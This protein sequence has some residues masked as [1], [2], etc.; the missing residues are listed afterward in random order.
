MRDATAPGILRAVAFVAFLDTF[1]MLPVLA[2][3]ARQLGASEA[4]AG[5]IVGVYSLANLLTSAGAGVLLDR[6]GRRLPMAVS[7]MTAGVLVA[8]YG[9][10]RD[11]WLLLMVR[12]LHGASGAVFIPA[13]FALVGEHGQAN[14]V[15]AMGQTGAT[16]GLVALLA[17]PI[18][19]I[20]AERYGEPSLFT[21]IALLMGLTGLSA[22]RWM[23]ER[24]VRPPREARIHPL[25]VL[26]QTALLSVYLLTFG[27]TFAM[28]MLTYR[29]PVMLEAVS[30]G[31]AYRGRLFGLFALLSV[32]VMVAVRRRAALGGAFQRAFTGVA[33]IALGALALETVALPYGAWSAVMLFGAGFGLCFPA[34]HL[35][36]YE[37]VESHL[38]GTAL[39]LLYAFYSLG[40][41]LGPIGAGLSPA[42][43]PAGWMGALVA[44]LC[45]LT[46]LTL[47]DRLNPCT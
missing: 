22:L 26:K 38:R 47:R 46:A 8:L 15:R 4:Q 30:Y 21:G 40:Y 27:M 25:I 18:G 7:L 20:V 33:L 36:A 10:V 42:N 24:Y 45:L 43:L 1:A 9:L 35:L 23:P 41:V 34:V 5:L 31:A 37:S 16:I 28:G 44:G 17:P 6:W 11:W 13:L 12:A 14:R 3:Y 39:A 2:P 19:G 32:L 29:L